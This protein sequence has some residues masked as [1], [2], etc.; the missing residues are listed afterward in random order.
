MKIFVCKNRFEDMMSSIYDA[1]SCALT[2]G[3]DNVFLMCGPVFQESILDEYIYV[4]GDREKAIKVVRSVSG[5][6]HS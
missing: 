1:W 3:H 2:C 5:K 6:I 4:E